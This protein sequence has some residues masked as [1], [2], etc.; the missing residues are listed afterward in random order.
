MSLQ[1]SVSR[2]R[3]RGAILGP[4]LVLLTLLAPAIGRPQAAP[5]AYQVEI[6]VFSTGGGAAQ[7]EDAAGQG[8]RA[9]RSTDSGERSSGAAQASR[10]LGLLPAS[11]L[12]L[13]AMKQS[14]AASASYRPIAHAGWTQ[15]AASWGAR[16]GTP[17]QSLGIAV[18]GLSGQVQLE[19]GSYLH[20]GVA[21]RYSPGG[22]GAA[23]EITEMRRVRF[24]EKHYFDH[25]G[26]GV[27]AM[28]SPAR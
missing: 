24:N 7:R 1:R 28:V 20:L 8:V 2:N 18:P 22:S 5:T 17:L 15:S 4:V 25:P 16:S 14:L 21:L 6:I 11:Q 26:F 19:R 10:L 23:Q 13:T 12:K 3:S 27:I 9:A